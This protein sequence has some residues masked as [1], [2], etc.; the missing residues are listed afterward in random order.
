MDD[1]HLERLIRSKS[2]IGP[3]EICGERMLF[4]GGGKYQCKN[5]HIA[6]DEFG[7]VKNYLEEHGA[8]P[9][10]VIEQATGISRQQIQSFLENG[11]IEIPEG[12]QYYLKCKLCNAPLR[13]GQ[14]CTC[15][16][17]KENIDYFSAEVGERPKKTGKMHFLNRNK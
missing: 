4:V 10:V 6:Y 5:K 7:V 2:K 11:R 12:S 9:S 13:F 14:I 8:T 15:C 16:A 17:S 3:C 1:L